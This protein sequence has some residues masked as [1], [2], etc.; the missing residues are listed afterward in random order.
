MLSSFTR[1]QLRACAAIAAIAV[2]PVLPMPS[3][4]GQNATRQAPYQ[5]LGPAL[6]AGVPRSQAGATF[7]ARRW[8][9]DDLS[10]RYTASGS[11]L[12]FRYRVVDPVKAQVLG[13]PKAVPE[14]IDQ[15][16]GVRLRVPEVDQV[17]MLRQQGKL[18]ASRQY[19]VMFPNPGKS[20]KP[21]DRVDVVIGVSFR[22]EGLVVE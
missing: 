3:H 19:W 21:G 10:V 8:G 16:R 17:G 2:C 12:E 14:L 1:A 9:V 15:R 7:Y 5:R 6:A 20:I 13:D 22:V 4:A 18:L 11:L